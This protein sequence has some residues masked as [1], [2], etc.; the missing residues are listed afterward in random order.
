M[1]RMLKTI[2]FGSNVGFFWGVVVREDAVATVY[3]VRFRILRNVYCGKGFR[4]RRFPKEESNEEKRL[5]RVIYLYLEP[6]STMS[7]RC[8][9]L[10]C[11]YL[12]T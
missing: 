2:C 4:A 3:V 12:F 10:N 9:I 7:H 1:L 11:Y 5:Q 6:F 8:L